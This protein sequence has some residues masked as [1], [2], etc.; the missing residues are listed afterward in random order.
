MI[1]KGVFLK[2]FNA[3]FVYSDGREE[4]KNADFTRD[5]D[6]ITVTLK[7]E[8]VGGNV[9]Y[10]DI[11]SDMFTAQTGSEGYMVIPSINGTYLC[12]YGEKKDETYLSEVN[13]MPVFGVKKKDEVFTVTAVK[14]Q[15]DFRYGIVLKDGKYS[16]FARFLIDGDAPYED[17]EL[18]IRMLDCNATYV[19]MAKD[20]RKYQLG[21]GAC[22]PLKERVKSNPK[23]KYGAESVLIR[24]RQAW[25]RVPAKVLVQTE[26][27]EPPVKAVCTFDRAGEIADAL[28][29]RGVDKAEISLVGWNMK[30]HDGRWPQ[31]F[32]VEETLGGEEK[33]KKFIKKAN[34]DGYNVTCHTNSTAMYNIA[35]TYCDDDILKNKDGEKDIVAEYWSG[36][37]SYRLC[38]K[39]SYEKYAK[40]ILPKVAD[41]GFSGI[42]YIDVMS[43]VNPKKCY[44]KNHPLNTKEYVGYLNKIMKLSKELMG[45]F[46]SEGPCDFASENLDFA[47]YSHIGMLG[48]IPE[49]FDKTVP[50]WQIVYHGIILY[51]PTTECV[52]YPI[53]D[54]KTH[55]KFIEYGGRPAAYIYS[56]FVEN[57]NEN[58]MGTDD[59]T[60]ATDKELDD[61]VEKIGRMYDEY[62]DICALQYEFIENH[63]EIS[64]NVFEVTYSDGSK[65]TVDYNDLSYKIKRG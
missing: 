29:K 17:I 63:E 42:H 13:I 40:N 55:L 11:T 44:D 21:R 6:K 62:K 12:G 3:K 9:K 39:V 33:L 4:I 30:G 38:P 35:D 57:E 56:K 58:W 7:K 60:C 15:Y 23:L 18:E 45:G 51:N 8:A 19:D 50:F 16:A 32:P 54:E 25:K 28:K 20:Y 27:N 37:R 65:I 46:S 14:M 1:K 47:L 49:I 5:N 52:N 59:L 61:A 64:D 48:K 34:A 31:T 43:I 22:I 24:I 26:E 53:K 36:G 10:I 2:M 41:V